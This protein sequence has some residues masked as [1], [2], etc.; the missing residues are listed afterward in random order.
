[1]KR[2][3][4]LCLTILIL[5][6][7]LGACG[8]KGADKSGIRIYYLNKADHA[9]QDQN[10]T[11][12]ADDRERIIEELIAKLSIQ[13]K[14][15]TLRAP[16]TDFRLLNSETKGSIVTLNF[17]PEYYDLSA[18]E[19]VLTRTAIVNTM[20][21]FSEIDG[22]YFLVNGE[23]LHD[24]DGEEPGIM[25]PDQFIYNSYTEMRNYE[26]VRLHL[27]FANEAG[28]RLVDA[29]RTVV[30]NSNMPLERIVLEQVIQGPNGNFAYPT[31]NKDT[32]VINITTRD[33]I[34]YVN[35]SD[36]FSNEHLDVTPQVA[37]YS[38]VNS[39]CELPSIDTVQISVDGQQ[40]TVFMES[41]SLTGSFRV[42]E[43]IVEGTRE[44][45]GGRK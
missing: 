26:R 38:I 45:D 11:P 2:R 25:E 16:V 3:T 8:R 31:V 35:L 43:D 21:S 30:Y 12:V 7:F 10:Y 1:M 29:Y 6:L 44:E 32:K 22:V 4:G 36:E 28:N 39:L 41:I 23:E 19:E 33:G 34:C 42:N 5:C 18:V 27:Y 9:L 15:M 37:L 40:D 20:C 14:E 24:A 13:P 17:S